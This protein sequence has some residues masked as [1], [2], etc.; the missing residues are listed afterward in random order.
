V[1][2][3][4]NPCV[5]P[6]DLARACPPP[7][8]CPGASSTSRSHR[9]P[10][11]RRRH[12]PRPGGRRN[13]DHPARRH[14]RPGGLPERPGGRSGA[15]RYSLCVRDGPNGRCAVQKT[16]TLL[17]RAACQRWLYV[18]TSNG[19]ICASRSNTY[20]GF[21]S[22]RVPR[23]SSCARSGGLT[24]GIQSPERVLVCRWTAATGARPAVCQSVSIRSASPARATSFC[25]PGSRWPGR[26]RCRP[27][28]CRPLDSGSAPLPYG[29]HLTRNVPGTRTAR[30]RMAATSS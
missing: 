26:A 27:R 29:T 12:P 9:P 20:A 25:R 2:T 24:P 18:G 14:R 15:P 7:S 6:S 21:R 16:C 1:E 30:L 22:W 17:G 5:A 19:A 10:L 23:P 11:V 13:R 3:P 4:P 8:S 28:G